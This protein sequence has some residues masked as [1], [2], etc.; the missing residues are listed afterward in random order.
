MPVALLCAVL[1]ASGP[2]GPASEV[3]AE[4]AGE[5]ITRGRVALYLTL[6]RVPESRWEPRWDGAVRELEDRAL[7]RRFL[8]A[9]R[10]VPEESVVEQQTERLLGRLG[11]DEAAV[12]ARLRDLGV[13]R[14]DVTAE[15]AL[16]KAWEIQARRLITPEVL[17]DYFEA[18]RRKYDGT[19]LAVSQIFKPGDA[20]DTLKAVKAKIDAGTLTFADAARTHSEAPSGEAGGAI[21]PVRYLTGDAPA[22]VAEAAF[23][24]ET[25]TV[26]GPVRSPLGTHL[27]LVTG[28][29]EPGEL[30][31]EDVRARVRRDL[32]A[33]L[34]AEQVNRLRGGE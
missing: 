22:A 13:T 10:A 23:A 28:V 2:D 14:A 17:R 5:S 15:A 18:N 6:A 32:K 4:A 1:L 3:L 11:E 29:A 24:A 16:P 26:V 12:D 33:E 20:A 31:L 9:R 19:A 21:G 34:W 7:M 25:G 27:V 8:K 30:S